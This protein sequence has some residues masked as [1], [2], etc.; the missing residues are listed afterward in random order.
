MRYIIL[1]YS[2]YFNAYIIGTYIIARF[3]T[4]LNNKHSLILVT[5]YS[6]KNQVS[7]HR[8]GRFE[9]KNQQT[10][11]EELSDQF[12]GAPKLS[13]IKFFSVL[14]RNVFQ[15]VFVGLCADWRLA[16]STISDVSE[17]ILGA[18]SEKWWIK[19]PQFWLTC[20]L[21]D[22]TGHLVTIQSSSITILISQNGR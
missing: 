16:S 22:V 5:V 9:C 20:Q 2:L 21:L 3:Q 11:T 4:I 6:H 17:V 7:Y 8:A 13:F 15:N 19:F 18:N 1:I 10:I 12:Y 14:L